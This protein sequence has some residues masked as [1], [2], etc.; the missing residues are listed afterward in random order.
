MYLNKGYRGCKT[1]TNKF[2]NIDNSD[3]VSRMLGLNSTGECHIDG[4]LESKPKKPL[5]FE[6]LESKIEQRSLYLKL[7]LTI[8]SPE[9]TL[10]RESDNKIK[11]IFH[12]ADLHIPNDNG[13]SASRIPEYREVFNRC[14][15]DFISKVGGRPSSDILIFIAGDIFDAAKKERGRVSA[16]AIDLFKSFLKDMQEIGTVVIIAGNHDNNITWKSRDTTTIDV[17]SS[18]LSDI[19]ELGNTIFYLKDTGRY[20]ID[21]CMFYTVSVFDLDKNTGLERHKLRVEL[22]PDK[23]EMD[24]VDHHILG[25]HCGIQ[26]Q[27]LQN[28]HILKG[29]A[30]TIGDLEHF[31][32][33]L[34]GDTHKLQ[35]LGV[36][37]N[38]AYPSSLL[39]QNFGEDTHNHGYIN[40]DLSVGSGQYLGEFNDIHNRRGLIKLNLITH[41]IEYLVGE[42]CKYPDKTDLHVQIR[43]SQETPLELIQSLKDTIKEAM[44]GIRCVYQHKMDYINVKNIVTDDKINNQLKFL[45]YLEATKIPE[46]NHNFIKEHVCPL[47]ND[48]NQGSNSWRL[49]EL[50]LH[51]FLTTKGTQ[52]IGFEDTPDNSI[53]SIGGNCAAGKSNI[54]RALIFVIWGKKGVGA[55]LESLINHGAKNMHVTFK[56]NFNN[57]VHTI[58][59]GWEGRGVQRQRRSAVQIKG[60]CKYSI[61]GVSQKEGH[62]LETDKEIK[63]VFNEFDDAKMTWIL[64]QNARTPTL[65]STVFDRNIGAWDWVEKKD[66]IKNELKGTKKKITSKRKQITQTQDSANNMLPLKEE[67]EVIENEIA[68]NTKKKDDALQCKYLGTKQDREN[69]EQMKIE[70]GY[71]LGELKLHKAETV[72]T[73]EYEELLGDKATI[74]QNLA[75]YEKKKADLEGLRWELTNLEKPKYNELTLKEES[76]KLEKRRDQKRAEKIR[77]NTIINGI[78]FNE[79]DYETKEKIRVTLL[80]NIAKLRSR[81]KTLGSKRRNIESGI[82]PQS[83][84]AHTIIEQSELFQA[85]TIEG[86]QI[87]SDLQTNTFKRDSLNN[88]L[89]KFAKCSCV[90]AGTWINSSDMDDCSCCRGNKSTYDIDTTVKERNKYDKIIMELTEA[91]DNCDK[92]IR[93]LQQ[94]IKKAVD[95]KTNQ[96]LLQDLVGIDNSVKTIDLTLEN[97]NEKHSNITKELVVL[98]SDKDRKYKSQIELSKI[99]GELD[100]ITFDNNENQNKLNLCENYNKKTRGFSDDIKRA[101]EAMLG[102]NGDEFNTKLK[103]CTEKIKDYNI[104]IKILDLEKEVS[105]IAEKIRKCRNYDP[106]LMETMTRTLKD[107]N[108]KRDDINQKLSYANRMTDDYNAYLEEEKK[109]ISESTNLGYLITVLEGWPKQLR[110]DATFKLTKAVN[111]FIEF[112][113]FDFK[114]IFEWDIDA[115]QNKNCQISYKKG[116]DLNVAFISGAEQS[117]FRLALMVGLNE[118]TNLNRSPILFIDEG[119]QGWDKL[120]LNNNLK[121]IL[122]YLKNYY[123]YTLS[124]SHIESVQKCADIKWYINKEGRI[125]S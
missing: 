85:K 108:V 74:S 64:Q 39:Q 20:L 65:K 110:Q 30:Y 105:I 119:F 78:N 28:G 112:S 22:L 43:C 40:W 109:L 120:H 8:T 60:Y 1:Y 14:I 90:N 123:T 32:I 57:K 42:I 54:Q 99:L 16:N 89:A 91:K 68:T 59:R 66:L 81:K 118:I 63:K 19:N 35:F 83:E 21:N 7:K 24:K 3:R 82:I 98:T 51:N 117:A 113:G 53:I 46:E 62:K 88:D 79:K 56:F 101:E 38:I 124:I 12:I 75:S 41:N 116:N 17:I 5:S 45:T 27:Q 61:D 55:K 69:W 70:M 92:T 37:E 52:T 95:L 23:I 29:Y 9:Y 73:E 10:C 72:S 125:E 80:K 31:D 11:S 44:P 49:I 94:Y 102:I 106:Y 84:D 86:I 34:L 96:S 4:E 2:D 77:Y 13:E 48:S 18:I 25:I 15:V 114:T 107:L 6:E 76:A 87:D 121:G 103:I 111:K 93:N 36:R 100:K 104:C 122:D 97:H 50:K 71:E 33:V 26:G 58:S 67:L 115:R 47:F